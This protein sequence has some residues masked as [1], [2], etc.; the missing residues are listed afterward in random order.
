MHQAVSADLGCCRCDHFYI[1]S[2]YMGD[3]AAGGER[4]CDTSHRGGNPGFL[5]FTA[6]GTLRWGDY[7][8]NRWVH[9][10]GAAGPRS[11]A[12]ADAGADH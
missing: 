12:A 11:A 1:T 10:A 4:G 7:T 2:C 8:G 5:D 3:T 6:P 9:V